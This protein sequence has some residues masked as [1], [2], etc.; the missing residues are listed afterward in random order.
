MPDTVTPDASAASSPA[1]EVPRTSAEYAE[2]RQTGKLPAQP[3]SEASAPSTDHSAAGEKPA[4]KPAPAS[5]AGKGT[6][7]KPK[8]ARD[9]AAARLN[10]LLDDL[11]RAGYTPAELKTLRREATKTDQAAAPAKPATEQTA[12]PAEL[13][14]PTKPKQE[15]FKTYEEFELARDKYFEDLADFKAQ[16][17]VE[18]FQ[19][20]QEQKAAQETVR[21]KMEEARTRYSSDPEAVNTISATARAITGDQQ[22]PLTV[23]AILDQSPVWPDILYTLG[24]KAEE[25]ASFI[26]LSKSNPGAAIRKA[27]LLEQLVTQ[28]LAKGAKPSAGE[29]ATQRD[30]T[31]KFVAE[32][33]PEKKK[34]P[35]APPPP[36]EVSGRGTPPPD[37]VEGAVR[38]N[39][40][41][42]YRASQNARDAALRRGR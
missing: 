4:E 1:L 39:D 33:P 19:Q 29:G 5:E 28:E 41:R 38:N 14:P 22:I 36:T 6:Q 32:K 21:Q 11:R 13:K 17:R 34:E 2:W 3:K 8:P 23:K 31:G 7:E 10:E 16:K 9:N 25:L 20:Q 40:F 30:E 18:E 26:E 35:A 27:V 12:N 24:S 15:D 42:R 37:E